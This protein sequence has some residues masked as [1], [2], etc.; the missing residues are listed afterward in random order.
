MP[1]PS[2]SGAVYA[3]MDLPARIHYAGMMSTVITASYL[4]YIDKFLVGMKAMV[5]GPGTGVQVHSCGL[6]SH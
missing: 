2:L 5:V 3:T 6:L 1:K 4:R